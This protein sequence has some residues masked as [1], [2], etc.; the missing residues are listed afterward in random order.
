MIDSL[1]LND[2]SYTELMR[3]CKFKDQKW[4]LS[5][6][7]T[8]DGFKGENFHNKCDGKSN[9]L[10][11]IKT[12]NQSIFGGFTSA[13]WSK[14]DGFKEDPYAF[15]FSYANKSNEK[16]IIKCSEPSNAIS[17][18]ENYGPCFGNDDIKISNM[19]NSNNESESVL[20]YVYGDSLFEY[21][22]DES[23]NFLAGAKFFQTEEIEVFTKD[24]LYPSDVNI[25]YNFFKCHYFNA[26]IRN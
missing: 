19:S 25:K 2:Q 18:N 20:G 7:A 11:V 5:Y 23:M 16:I 4:K 9:T 15:L 26:R 6:R 17:C 22:S 1:V 24:F 21:G 12:T 10:T 3:L 8:R 14:N 13:T